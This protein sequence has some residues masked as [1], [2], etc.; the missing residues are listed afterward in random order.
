MGAG[1]E[2]RAEVGGQGIGINREEVGNARLRGFE[3]D[4]GDLVP[5]PLEDFTAMGGSSWGKRVT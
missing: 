4:Q 5:L 2:R 3:T 1:G